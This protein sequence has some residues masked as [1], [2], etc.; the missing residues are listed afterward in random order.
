VEEREVLAVLVVVVLEHLTL[1][2]TLETEPQILGL[3]V[4][5]RV[6]EEPT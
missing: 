2:I 6:L 4:A 1:Q 5:A 3:A